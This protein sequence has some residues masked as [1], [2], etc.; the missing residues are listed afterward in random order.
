MTLTL[1]SL[2][3]VMARALIVAAALSGAG[4]DLAIWGTQGAALAQ[5]APGGGGGRAGAPGAGGVPGAA[6]LREREVGTVALSSQQVPYIVTLPGR[7]V[8]FEETIVRPR[9]EGIV[10]EIVYS[11]GREVAAGDILFRLDTDTYQTALSAAEANRDSALAQVTVAEARAERDRRLS[12]VG[13]TRIDSEASVAA[14]AQA[15]AALSAA[16]AALKTAQLNLDR[17]VIRSPISGVAGL[18]QVSVGTLV[19]ANQAQG[20]VTITRLDP[21]YV[22]VAESSARMLQVRGRMEAGELAP[23]ETLQAELTLEDGRVHRGLGSFVSPGLQVSTT[24]GSVQLRFSFENPARDILPGQFLRVQL[25]L[26]TQEAILVPQRAT[27]RAADGSLTAFIVSEGKAKQV[28]LTYSGTYKNA[29]IT[30]EGVAPGDLLIVDGLNN[31]RAGMAV[32]SIPVTIDAR[33]VVQDM[34]AEAKPA[35]N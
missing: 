8:A 30:T 16:E 29:W 18:P 5:G 9:V 11:P 35:S 15:K 17:A 6:A 1:P 33:G 14:L 13:A 10:D 24:T 26:G 3:R 12:G 34:P 22:D 7:A 28:T 27:R 19:T 2:P 4:T 23:G 32:K 25:T 21:I 31:L 20:L